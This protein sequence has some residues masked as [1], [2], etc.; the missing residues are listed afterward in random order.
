MYSCAVVHPGEIDAE[1]RRDWHFLT[2]HP[3]YQSALLHPDFARAVGQVREDTR[4]AL[5]RRDGRLEAVLA[6]H[7]R[8]GGL[9]RP[10]AAPFSD[11]QAFVCAPGCTLS[12]AEALQLARLR[13]FRFDALVDPRGRFGGVSSRDHVHAIV[14]GPDIGAFLEGLRAAN[15]KRFKNHR[16]LARQMERER[17]V[18]DFC[19]DDHDPRVFDQLFA[20]KHAQFARTGKHD[21]LRPAWAGKLMTSLFNGGI[22]DAKGLLVSLKAGGKLV[23]AL[24]GV[25]AGDRYNPWVAAYDPDCAPWSPG[26]TIL[27]LLVEAMPQ[28]G[29]KRC[30]LG[31]GHDHY[32][33]YYSNAAISVSAGLETAPGAARRATGWRNALWSA[34]ERFPVAALARRTVSAHR[35]LDQIAAADLD[36]T[37]RLTGTLRAVIANRSTAQETAA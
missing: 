9:A 25:R 12:G 17:G 6:F 31:T 27:H 35:R 4:A 10:L 14:P 33:K 15:P 21:V 3:D 37:G 1:T 20:W 18:L 30:D 28:L 34:G 26:Q 16:R 32:K 8:P 2:A 7:A 19:A 23:A 36:F 11:V 5:F 29:L 24:Y 22:G 13:A